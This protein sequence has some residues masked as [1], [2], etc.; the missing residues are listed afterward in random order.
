VTIKVTCTEGKELCVNSQ[1]MLFRN[2]SVALNGTACKPR[3]RTLL[4][5]WMVARRR[6]A[7]AVDINSDSH[8]TPL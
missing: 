1:R 3:K 4:F 5:A 7:S 6:G 2:I 8:A